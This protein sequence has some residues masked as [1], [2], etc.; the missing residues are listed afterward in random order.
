MPSLTTI[1]RDPNANPHGT[2]VERQAVRAV[3]FQG[4]QLLLVYS[5]VNRDYKFPGGGVKKGEKFEDA[6][7]R[8][9]L[10]E[11]G[12]QL[13][14]VVREIGHIV[15]YAHAKE[16]EFETFKMTSHYFLCEAD[17]FVSPQTL[18]EYEAELD[19]QPVWVELAAAL[20]TNNSRLE[21]PDPPRWTTRDTFML[22]YIKTHLM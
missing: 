15:E 6:L 21:Q 11:C 8:E 4:E 3:I 17:T 5:P 9:L 12:A 2:T 18:E 16:P 10:E 7:R 19:F 13:T 1:F 22:E 20:Q 14:R